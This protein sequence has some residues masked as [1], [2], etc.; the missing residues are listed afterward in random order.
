MLREIL[1]Q[2]DIQMLKKLRLERETHTKK[3]SDIA[4]T[5]RAAGKGMT[6]AEKTDFDTASARVKEIDSEISRLE[7]LRS[8]QT[9]TAVE[10]HSDN[11]VEEF[12]NFLKNEEV[13]TQTVGTNTAGGFTVGTTVANRVIEAMKDTSG[14]I[15]SSSS[16][17]TST[18]GELSYPTMD[19]TANEAEIAAETDARR[20][21]PDVVFGSITLKS[22]VFDSGIIKI[23]NELVQDSAVNIEQIVI[24]QLSNRIARKLEKDF[25]VGVGTTAPSGLL[26]QTTLGV[27]AAAVDAVT[28][29]ELLDL[30]FSI[31]DAYGSKGSYMMNKNTLLA[32]S[33]LKDGQGNYLI[34]GRTLF[35][36]PIKVNNNMPDMATGV[37]AITFG[38]VSQYMVRNVQGL[39]I[40]KFNELYQETNEI[41][42]KASGRFDGTLLNPAAVKHMLMA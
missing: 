29:D 10:A 4:G 27:T 30:Q 3:M 8:F 25:T 41:G 17:S 2:K 42:Y 11:D 37:K 23:S 5:E 16:I 35:E 6:D 26:T 21:G 36:K 9:A 24:S 14:M 7:E 12:R 20:T 19:D 31:D 38:D 15:A 34:S 13:R 22:F 1:K 18:G 32:I 33:K 28:A 39:N 40:F